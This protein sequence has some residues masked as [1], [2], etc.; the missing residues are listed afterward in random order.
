MQ[1]L[2]F[3]YKLK[4]DLSSQ[5]HVQTMQ[6]IAGKNSGII[7]QAQVNAGRAVKVQEIS[8]T[9]KLEEAHVAKESA[10]EQAHIDHASKLH[11]EAFKA[12]VNNKEKSE[13]K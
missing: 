13:E 6:E 10:L 9:G 5:E 11:Q 1:Y 7:Q 3:E 8:T 12:A 4:A 2:Q